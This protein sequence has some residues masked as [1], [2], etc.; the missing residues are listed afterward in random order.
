MEKMSLK[1]FNCFYVLFSEY[2]FTFF[3]FFPP[4]T[5]SYDYEASKNCEIIMVGHM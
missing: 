4:S 3:H 1:S 5:Y 2:V